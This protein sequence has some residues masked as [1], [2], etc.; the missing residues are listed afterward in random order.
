MTRCIGIRGATTVDEDALE[1]VL[2]ATQDLLQRL[3]ELNGFDPAD[4]TS[5]I[6]TTSA[7]IRSTFPARAARRLGWT[8]V[9]MLCAQEIDAPE[10]LPRCVRVLLHWNTERP[11]A[12]VRHAYLRGSRILRPDWAVPP[13]AGPGGAVTAPERPI[14]EAEEAAAI[15]SGQPAP[16]AAPPA[17]SAPPRAVP[18]PPPTVVE[19]DP[20]A[21][22]GEPGSFSHEAVLT[23][24]GAD[25]PV[26]SGSSFRRVFEAVHSGR[27]KSAL[28]PV[29]NSTSGSVY[30]VYD[31]LLTRDLRIVAEVVLPVR[32]A[33]L[34]RPGT[35]LSDVRSVASHPQALS[36]CAGWVESHGWLARPHSDT[37]GAARLVAESDE[38][39]QAAIASA[40]A[41]ELLGLEVLAR[42]IQDVAENYTRFLLLVP[43]HLGAGPM[44]PPAFGGTWEGP[45]KTS[46]IFATRHVAGDLYA[47]LAEL[48]V[49]DV[50][51]TRI[52]SRP[53]RRTPWHYLFYLDFE[54][55]A[56]D[57]RMAQALRGLARHATFLRVLGS[58]PSRP[59]T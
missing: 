7:D 58:Y 48:A 3:Q 41:A 45:L 52:E 23:A 54:G 16:P 25:T 31:L 47:C 49:R 38:P 13:I 35:Q 59:L 10:A 28:L 40:I 6:F 50:N 56:Q 20:I 55:D 21:F 15:A 51:L 5:I 44:V 8:M 4:L 42:D 19:V 12:E 29:E 17:P 39:G 1:E 24:F 2:D 46:I 34:A 14:R 33:L 36:Q 26:V 57:P 43:S 11:A 53:D 32:H 9:P 22:L 18:P 30:E 37:A 27:A